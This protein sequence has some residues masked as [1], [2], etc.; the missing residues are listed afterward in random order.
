MCWWR[1]SYERGVM[2]WAG[3]RQHRGLLEKGLESCMHSMA[4]WVGALQDRKGAVQAR[5]RYKKGSQLVSGV[6][7]SRK[8]C[9]NPVQYLFQ[10]S[11]LWS[12]WT[13]DEFAVKDRLLC[14]NSILRLA[15]SGRRVTI[16]LLSLLSQRP[17][18]AKGKWLYI[19]PLPPPPPNEG[20]KSRTRQ[21]NF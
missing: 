11:H 5:A 7:L 1:V 14:I 2:M 15:R 19:P 20:H 10:Q 17:L 13:Q 16:A 6:K 8:E 12:A 18:L 4:C 3:G 9:S 21:E